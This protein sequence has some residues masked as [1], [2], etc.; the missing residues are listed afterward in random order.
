M[1][2]RHVYVKRFACR[3]L[4]SS[5]WFRA[6]RQKKLSIIKYKK[7][8]LALILPCTE[9]WPVGN[10]WSHPLPGF[11]R[12]QK[13]RHPSNHMRRHHSRYFLYTNRQ[14]FLKVTPAWQIII[15]SKAITADA[16][17]TY[18]HTNLTALDAMECQ[19]W[20]IVHLIYHWMFK[21][22]NY[23]KS[24]YGNMADWTHHQLPTSLVFIK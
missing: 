17:L 13:P 20:V 15:P 23:Q 16:L 5:S 14:F 24:K 4:F 21:T 8:Q 6:A 12:S 7:Y 18:P 1:R 22:F 10:K 3:T 19:S 11:R 9:K 2:L